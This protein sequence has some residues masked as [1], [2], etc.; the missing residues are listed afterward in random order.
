MIKLFMCKVK[1][2]GEDI[3]EARACMLLLSV[4]SYLAF[5]FLIVFL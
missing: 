2:A 4:K 1:H 3:A 5:C